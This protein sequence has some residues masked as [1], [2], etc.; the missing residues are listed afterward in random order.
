MT[1]RLPALVRAFGGPRYAI[2]LAVD[3]VG[4]GLL[5]PFLLLYGVDVLRLPALTAGLAMTAG[6]AAGLC[7]TPAMGRWLD[8]GA[9]STAVAASMLVRV[10]GTALLLIA[11][12]ASTGTVWQF[13]VAALFLG[14]GNQ[15]F[16]VAHAALV[17]TV[18][19]GRERDAALAA[20]RSV[21]NAGLGLGALIATACLA[22]GTPALRALAAGTGLSY[23]LSS[24]LAWSVRIRAARQPVPSRDPGRGPRPRAALAPGMRPL[25]AANVIYVFC[26][27]VPE[28]ALPLV[29]VTQLHASPVWAAGVFVTNTVLVVVFQVPV[30]VWM[31]RFSRR[32]ALAFSGIVLTVSYLGFLGGVE[33]GHGWAAPAVVGV[34]VLCTLGEIIY[35]GSS[36]ALVAATAPEQAVGRALARFQLS[37]GFGLAI[38]PAVI[39]A[40][41]ARGPAA[42]WACLAVAT[43][44]SS[45]AV[46]RDTRGGSGEV[47][48]QGGS[49]LRVLHHRGVPDAGQQLDAGAGHGAVGGR[50]G[51]GVPRVLGA[52]DH[53]QREPEHG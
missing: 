21:R 29:L 44:L 32:T 26:L 1:A 43:L 14:I 3:A 47:Q 51:G 22:G 12:A 37:T 10:V 5:R 39:T 41:A 6:V 45:A 50:R 27:N 42:L 38:S 52:E 19:A 2:A 49:G 23:L 36:T 48:Q 17:T 7:G 34:S 40:L 9:R 15:A 53:Q 20:G 33:L 31:S 35:A 4:T 30:T 8:R 24:A 28:V 16:P 13:A 18:S 46:N 25:L 11:P